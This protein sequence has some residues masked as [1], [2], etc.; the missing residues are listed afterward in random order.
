M[1]GF[2]IYQFFGIIVSVGQ[3]RLKHRQA[4]IKAFTKKNS[5][6]K[7]NKNL[8]NN[9]IAVIIIIEFQRLLMAITGTL[10][11]SLKHR[12]RLNITMP[13]KQTN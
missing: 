10:H 9:P 4:G 8:K 11:H 2:L 3:L 1:L 12:G 5:S 13:L 6:T 7:M